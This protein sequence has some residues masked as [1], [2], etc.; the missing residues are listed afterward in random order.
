MDGPILLVSTFCSVSIAPGQ[1]I[2][3]I[4]P[5][6]SVWEITSVA[7]SP[8]DSLPAFGRVVVYASSLQPDGSYTEKVAIAPLRIGSAEV[9]SVNYS[10]NSATKMVFSTTGD[11]IGVTINGNTATS[12]QLVTEIV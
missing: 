11:A 12:E 3:V 2:K 6:G 4:V 8:S 10:I 7:I 9:V 5:E 1:S